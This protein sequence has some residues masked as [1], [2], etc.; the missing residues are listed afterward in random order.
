MNKEDITYEYEKYFLNLMKES[1]TN[2]YIRAGEINCKRVFFQHLK[3][4]GEALEKKTFLGIA[5]E[6]ADRFY[7][8]FLENYEE[9]MQRLYDVAA[10]EWK[11]ETYYSGA[12]SAGKS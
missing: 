9:K 1:K 3:E 6:A 7:L 5:S 12:G 11:Q 8:F 2:L 4:K 10:D